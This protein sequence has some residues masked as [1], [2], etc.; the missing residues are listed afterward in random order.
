MNTGSNGWQFD[1][2]INVAN[3]ILIIGLMFSGFSWLN[4]LDQRITANS[5]NINHLSETQAQ[6]WQLNKEARDEIKAQLQE[7]DRKLDRLLQP[8]VPNK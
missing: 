5:I 6:Y 1:R 8:V 3:L 7:I 2:K 4:Q